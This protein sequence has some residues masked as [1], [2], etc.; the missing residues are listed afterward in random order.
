MI[1]P[2]GGAAS[3][4]LRLLQGIVLMTNTKFRNDTSIYS[5]LRKEEEEEEEKEE[6]DEE[7][8]EEEE[9][10]ERVEEEEEEEEE[11]RQRI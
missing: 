3:K 6:E 11:E 2:L 8:E 5:I 4:L 9:E 1:L 10:E 7:E